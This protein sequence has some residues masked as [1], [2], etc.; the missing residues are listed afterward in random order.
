MQAISENPDGVINQIFRRSKALIGMIHCP[1]FPGSPRYRG[2]SLNQIYDACLR[3]AE[4]LVNNGLH[5]LIVENHGD[6]P[7]SKPDDIGPETP[8][9]MA[10]VVERIK[11]NFDVPIGINVLA[12]APITAFAIA[13]ATDSAFI[14][15][16]QW[17]NAYIANEGFME[18]RAAQA[19]RFRSAL[20]GEGIKVFADSHVKHGSH[21]I[22]SDRSIGELTRDLDFFDVDAVIATGH[23]TGDSATLEEIEEVADATSLPVL[24][25]SGVDADNIAQ[26]L[27]RAS[28]V[29]VA[30]SLKKDG[31]W[32]NPVDPEKVR[33]FVT[34]AT[35][36]LET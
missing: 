15:V 26:I 27:T 36:A 19:M 21:S 11:R 18:G 30:S 8:A 28:A 16:N 12:N 3:D 25:G 10:V 1:P 5:G 4:F 13:R 35:P 32:W 31:V 17:A 6:V 24:V 14:R 23:R 34:A 2:E 9:F 33:S 20:R 7:F 22:T 29:I